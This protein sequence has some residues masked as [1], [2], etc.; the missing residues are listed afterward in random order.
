MRPDKVARERHV[1]AAGDE[2]G[3]GGEDVEAV[4]LHAGHHRH[5]QQR[6]QLAQRQQRRQPRHPQPRARSARRV[7]LKIF[8]QCIENIYL[9]NQKIFYRV[10]DGGEHQPRPRVQRH[11]QGPHVPLRR[12]APDGG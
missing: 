5:Q 12:V 8:A 7:H 10:V 1:E 11:H 9:L 3:A 6:G 2:E 4:E